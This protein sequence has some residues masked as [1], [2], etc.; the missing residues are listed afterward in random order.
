MFFLNFVDFTLKKIITFVWKKMRCRFDTFFQRYR[1]LLVPNC[2]FQRVPKCLGAELSFSTG[3]ELSCFRLFRGRRIQ[4]DRWE[5]HASHVT[6]PLYGITMKKWCVMMWK[7]A[8]KNY[9]PQVFEKR[10][11][12][13]FF[14]HSQFEKC[15]ALSVWSIETLLYL[16]EVWYKTKTCTI[17]LNAA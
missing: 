12:F 1:N 8:N 9:F 6:W 5:I 11:S 3:A 15:H 17:V 10:W 2:L 16:L 7:V 13:D 4:C 14:C